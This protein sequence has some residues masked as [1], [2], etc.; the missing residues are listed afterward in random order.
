MKYNAL[1]LQTPFFKIVR[2]KLT[3][4]LNASNVLR[5]VPEQ[6]Y[7]IYPYMWKV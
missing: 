3:L 2:D 6:R 7:L 1:A 4:V 5:I